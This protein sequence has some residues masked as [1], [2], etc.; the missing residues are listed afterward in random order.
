MNIEWLLL[1][2]YYYESCHLL[3]NATVE[4]F[5]LKFTYLLGWCNKYRM[6][7]PVRNTQLAKSTTI[8]NQNRNLIEIL[9]VAG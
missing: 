7:V 2:Y 5:L 1:G 6:V 9:S 8:E 3:P 4:G